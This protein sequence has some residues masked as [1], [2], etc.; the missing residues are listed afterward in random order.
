V[1]VVFAILVGVIIAFGIALHRA[2]KSSGQAASEAKRVELTIVRDAAADVATEAER[3]AADA[4]RKAV[5]NFDP[6]E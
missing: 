2:T 5:E 4:L 6:N 1:F 3:S